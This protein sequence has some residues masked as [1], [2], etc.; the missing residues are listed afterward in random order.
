MLQLTMRAQSADIA[1]FPCKHKQG[2]L[3]NFFQTT[4]AN[5]TMELK[6]LNHDLSEFG[7]QP[8]DWVLIKRTRSQIKIQH[9]AEPSFFF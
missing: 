2:E 6:G 9:R 1:T 4:N 8:I 7:L 3:M 5:H